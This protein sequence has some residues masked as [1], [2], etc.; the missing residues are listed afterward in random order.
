M[1]L[2]A[3]QSDFYEAVGLWHII[4]CILGISKGG[5]I[6]AAVKI[7]TFWQVVLLVLAI[8]ILVKIMSVSLNFFVIL[9][10]QLNV[11]EGF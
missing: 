7:K 5:R 1:P 2:E 11:D 3:G 9:L 10:A 4:C 6:P 8:G